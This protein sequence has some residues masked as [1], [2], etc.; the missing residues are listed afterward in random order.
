MATADTATSSTA[1]CTGVEDADQRGEGENGAVAPRT[2]PRRAG[3]P[4]DAS[5]EALGQV[6]EQIDAIIV[7]T[8][9]LVHRC[10]LRPSICTRAQQFHT[11]RLEGRRFQSAVA[12][13]AAA[14]WRASCGDVARA[15][16]AARS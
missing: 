6:E 1:E 15:L 5:G 3:R 8:L 10:R 12:R 4:M 7:K 9:P 16:P 2:W 13:R 14:P 11:S